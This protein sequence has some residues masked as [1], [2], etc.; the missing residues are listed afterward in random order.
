MRKPYFNNTEI[1]KGD[2]LDFTIHKVAEDG[3]VVNINYESEEIDL[4]DDGE[5]WTISAKTESLGLIEWK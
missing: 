4:Y 5:G 3:V 1:K 2:I